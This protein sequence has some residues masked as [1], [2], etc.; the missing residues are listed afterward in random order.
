MLLNAHKKQSFYFLIPILLVIIALFAFYPVFNNNFVHYDDSLYIIENE[1]IQNGLNPASIKWAFTS[2]QAKNWH[3]LTWL[4]HMADYQLFGL[5]P[6]GHHTANLLWHILNTLLIF[7]LLKLIT[8]SF[9]R[10]ALVS[11]LFA[12]HP[13]HVESVAWAAE[14]K[15]VLSTFWGLLTIGAY[16]RGKG[17]GGRGTGKLRCVDEETRHSERLSEESGAVDGDLRRMDE[18]T[19]HSERLSEESGA[20][21]GKPWYFL[22]LT[23]FTLSLL[24]KPMLVT[25][26]LVLL[27]L[28]FWPLRTLRREEGRMKREEVLRLVFEKL[29]LFVLAAFSAALTYMVQ[30]A[31]GAVKSAI[32]FSMRIANAVV[33][34]AAYILKTILPLKLSVFYPFPETIPG[35]QIA[36]S[37]LLLTTITLSAIYFRKKNPY[38]LCGWLWFLIT[39]IPVIGLVKVG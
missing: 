27:L 11:A 1:H 29:P 37:A 17:C 33:S 7:Y 34:Y 20:V 23:F 21:M 13:L 5:D 4:S 36:G 22:T 2:V 24:A 19:R 3:P 15:D 28:D 31:S 9:W 32:P 39:L 6:R 10:S 26:P 30:N 18:E 35:W 16:A 14:R 25:L 8:G 12:V 38:F